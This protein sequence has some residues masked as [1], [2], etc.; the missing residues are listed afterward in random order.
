MTFSF[1]EIKTD[2]FKNRAVS[3]DVSKYKKHPERIEQQEHNNN[4][5]IDGLR[6]QQSL[7]DIILSYRV[8]KIDETKII[9][10]TPHKNK[11]QKDFEEEDI[12]MTHHPFRGAIIPI[13]YLGHKIIHRKPPLKNAN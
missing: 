6:Q 5:A 2:F 8:I 12:K 10:K 4:N 3:D 9:G 11:N 1:A 7:D 13:P